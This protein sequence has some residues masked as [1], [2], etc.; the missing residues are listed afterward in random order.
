MSTPGRVIAS[1]RRLTR[2][3]EGRD[4]ENG[5]QIG[6]VVKLRSGGL[7]MTVVRIREQFDGVEIECEWF[8]NLAIGGKAKA[9]GSFPP[10]ALVKF[11][12]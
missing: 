11:G 6:D 8:E 9:H 4:V 1:V 10:A 12:T 5:F 2:F 7:R 3:V